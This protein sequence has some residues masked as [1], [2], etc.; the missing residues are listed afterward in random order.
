[1]REEVSQLFTAVFH[2]FRAAPSQYHCFLYILGRLFCGHASY[3][4]L[5]FISYLNRN[6]R[7]FICTYSC[8]PFIYYNDQQIS[9]TS[10][11]RIPSFFLILH[12]LQGHKQCRNPR[13]SSHE[14]PTFISPER[15]RLLFALSGD[16]ISFSQ[17]HLGS[18]KKRFDFKI[19]SPFPGMGD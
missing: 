2:T 4:M 10:P 11:T 19:C 1:M 12:F 17:F 18:V 15:A 3:K 7:A 9:Y 14:I 8:W 5:Q 16:S 6:I 13:R